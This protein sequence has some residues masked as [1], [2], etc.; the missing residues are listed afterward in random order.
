MT[1]KDNLKT[2]VQEAQL[3]S[4]IGNVNRIFWEDQTGLDSTNP[5]FK[6]PE[7]ETK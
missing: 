2:Y 7:N 5:H 3:Q 6:N 1:F 4:I